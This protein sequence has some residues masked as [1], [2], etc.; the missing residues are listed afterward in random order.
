MRITRVYTRSGDAGETSLATGERIPKD[1][2][3][4]EAYGT[5]DELNAALAMARAAV[6]ELGRIDDARRLDETL[7]RA[8]SE[9]FCVGAELAS[10]DPATLTIGRVTA[11][12]VEA[13]EGE[14]D[15]YND[16]LEP[17]T[18]FLL[19]GGGT[20]SAHLHLARVVCRRA[21][22]RAVALARL[23]DVEAA[24]LK[25]LNRLSDL[26]FV[27]ARWAARSAG[28]PE[29]LWSPTRD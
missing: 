2:A 23:V 21:E 11:D 26:L 5:V 18:E 9:L 1:D 7:R 20:A 4:V 13:I 24:V 16:D 8:Q 14:I 27:L 12:H 19:P 17:L 25:Y 15:A 10:P 3:R 22:R 29:Y 6:S 28:Q